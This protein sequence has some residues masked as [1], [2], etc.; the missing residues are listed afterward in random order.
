MLTAVICFGLYASEEWR[1]AY[2]LRSGCKLVSACNL[3]L[4]LVAACS[5]ACV[6][7]AFP[8]GMVVGNQVGRGVGRSVG[9]VVLALARV[10]G[11]RVGC[12]PIVGLV[13]GE[14]VG[15]GDR[16]SNVGNLVPPVGDGVGLMSTG[17][18]ED[19]ATVFASVAVAPTEPTK[20]ATICH[21]GL[22]LAHVG[23]VGVVDAAAAAVVVLRVG[24][25]GLPRVQ[26]PRLVDCRGALGCRC[27]LRVI[28]RRPVR[29]EAEV[30][31]YALDK[32]IRAFHVKPVHG[33]G[34]VAKVVLE[35]LRGGARREVPASPGA[36]VGEC[37]A[38]YSE[39]RHDVAAANGVR[40][41]HAL[42][43]VLA[44]DGRFEPQHRLVVFAADLASL[45]N[46]HV[47]GHIG[48]SHDE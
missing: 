36:D 34:V 6:L 12:R 25:I 31:I 45:A 17:V 3:M 46:P 26:H 22:E 32:T 38:I 18:G 37:D 4:P 35:A 11:R 48:I 15:E 21:L 9:A 16:L 33:A 43:Q 24:L 20:S 27:D 44:L 5:G 2:I 28:P 10:V 8:A 19:V 1:F 39:R 30:D 14:R 40:L 29:P 13:V 23:G 41:R 42:H 7:R 47:L